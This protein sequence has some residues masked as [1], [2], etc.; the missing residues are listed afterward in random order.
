MDLCILYLTLE[1]FI[2][3]RK[4]SNWKCAFYAMGPIGAFSVRPLPEVFIDSKSRFEMRRF[5]FLL[6]NYKVWSVW[7][8][9]KNPKKEFPFNL[10]K[11]YLEIGE[12]SYHRKKF[13][14]G[15]RE[16]LNLLANGDSITIAVKFFKYIY[17]YKYIYF[18]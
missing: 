14:K 18:H 5:I 8:N 2:D 3:F 7:I 13:W 1:S 16:T 9:K 10:F 6:K 12:L 4:W 11:S 17:I 15:I